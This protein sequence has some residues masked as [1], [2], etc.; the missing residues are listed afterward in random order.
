MP[1]R[2]LSVYDVHKNPRSMDTNNAQS[3]N[4]SSILLGRGRAGGVY[5]DL[6]QA[7]GHPEGWEVVLGRRKLEGRVEL[8]ALGG[9]VLLLAWCHCL[10]G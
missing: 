8:G 5:C 4:R 3:Q 6:R 2:Q 9:F 1:F 7:G 10:I